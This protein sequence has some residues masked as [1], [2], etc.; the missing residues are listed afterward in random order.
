MVSFDCLSDGEASARAGRGEGVSVYPEESAGPGGEW[1]EG[2]SGEGEDEDGG[3]AL[4]CEE[5]HGTAVQ[6]RALLSEGKDKVKWRKKNWIKPKRQIVF[7]PII[8]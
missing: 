6:R 5:R 1:G 3:G 8:Y 4:H 7:D 2:E